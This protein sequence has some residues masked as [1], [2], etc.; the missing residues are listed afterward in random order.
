MVAGM[1]LPPL[2]EA[3]QSFHLEQ[4]ARSVS[5][6]TARAQKGD[7]DKLLAHAAAAHWPAWEVKPRVLR[8]FALE[9]GER[10]LDP[11]SQSRILSTARAFFRWLFET[12]RIAI[13]PAVGLRN[14]KLPQRLPAFLT[15]E[16]SRA[17]LD[18]PPSVDFPSARLRCLLE[19]A[20]HAVQEVRAIAARLLRRLLQLCGDG[21]CDLLELGWVGG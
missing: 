15:E 14:P 9:L 4:L 11:A 13:N 19:L 20:R 2:A 5:P 6:H 3:I 17:L 16:E 12:Q 10:G 21:G 7:L 1:I 8:R 18:L